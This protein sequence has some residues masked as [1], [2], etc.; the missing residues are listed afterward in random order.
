MIIVMTRLAEINFFI[1]NTFFSSISALLATLDDR[2]CTI[3]HLNQSL[4]RTHTFFVMGHFIF[5]G[6]S[7]Q[8]T[9]FSVEFLG[10][11]EV[12][13]YCFQSTL[14]LYCFYLWWDQAHQIRSGSQVRFW[15][16]FL[17]FVTVS[18]QNQLMFICFEVFLSRYFVYLWSS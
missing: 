6:F 8:K 3:P 13:L 11:C 12:L 4:V 14:A 17:I 2:T 5:A 1:P 15:C 16:I 18:N 9:F 7:I 10:D